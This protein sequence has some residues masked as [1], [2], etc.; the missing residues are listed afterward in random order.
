ML[1]KGMR[2]VG[3]VLGRVVF[4]FFW[5][6]SGDASLGRGGTKKKRAECLITRPAFKNTNIKVF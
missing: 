6:A 2:G 4:C 3:L 5:A 1:T